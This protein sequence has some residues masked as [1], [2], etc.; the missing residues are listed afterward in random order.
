MTSIKESHYGAIDNVLAT[1]SG[2]LTLKMESSKIGGK[3]DAICMQFARDMYERDYNH[4]IKDL[5]S[6]FPIDFKRHGQEFW[7]G[8]K[9]FPDALAFDVEEEYTQLYMFCMANLLK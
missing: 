7:Q 9:R 4:T 6:T 3:P 2:L 5:T 8:V 1:I